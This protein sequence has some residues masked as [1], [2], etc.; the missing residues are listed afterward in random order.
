MKA[1]EP[2][3]RV[4]EQPG[5]KPFKIISNADGK[6]VGSSESRELADRSIV[7]RDAFHSKVAK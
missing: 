4:E 7:H 1:P 2:N 3:Y 6:Q 5:P